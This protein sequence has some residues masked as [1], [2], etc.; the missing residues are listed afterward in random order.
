MTRKVR[1][2]ADGTVHEG[3]VLDG[4]FHTD[5]GEYDPESVS[6]LPPCEPTK[7][8][9]AG[10]NYGE[11]VENII[12]EGF[13]KPEFPTFFFKPPSSILEP[14]KSIVKRDDVD[15]L[16]YEG[17]VGF[18]IGEECSDVA[19]DEALEY[20]AGYTPF[21]D[22]SARDWIAREDQWARGKSMDTFSPLGPYLQTELDLP[23]GLT[24]RVN[25]EVRQDSDT[26]DLFFDLPELIAEA[27]RYFTLQPGDVIATGTPPGTAAEDVPFDAWDEQVSDLAL[28]PGD[29]VEVSV[30]D[31]GVLR[32]DVV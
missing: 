13:P 19:E 27:S 12:G 31:A 7:I 15:F 25:G 30:E 11:H 8:V 5:D 23:V 18:I 16:D 28:N 9:A 2:E 1:F 20:V 6:L 29:V 32:N 21:N 4:A 10:M 24:T 22:V 26:S 3:T 14:G 17:E